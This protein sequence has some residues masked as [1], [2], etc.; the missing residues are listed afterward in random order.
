M[1][2][3]KPSCPKKKAKDIDVEAID[4][5]L[6]EILNKIIVG[7]ENPTT[8]ARIYYAR[9]R[10]AQVLKDTDRSDLY[11]KGIATTNAK[12]PSG[13][14][15]ALLAVCGDILLKNGDLDGAE[16]MFK[17]LSDRYRDS[18][19]SDA[20]P[21]GL[22]FVALARKQPE[23]ALKIFDEALENNPGMSRFKETTL[24]KLQVL[25]ELNK[26][27]AAEKLA[28]EIVGDKLFRGE[29]VRQS[30][31]AARTGLS[32]T[33]GQGGRGRGHRVAQEGPRHLSAGLCHLPGP[34]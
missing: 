2:S 24:G 10:L 6:V 7:Q 8:A 15:P 18:I 20:G 28:L 26:L 32:Q 23:E 16:T 25:I 30:L 5:Q 31:P 29:S 13:L 12:D 11:L 14:S 27:E 22:G 3:S 19:F 21:V 1:N 33:G 9:A 17:R 34:A 4:K